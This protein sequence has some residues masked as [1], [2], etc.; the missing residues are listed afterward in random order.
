LAGTRKVIQTTGSSTHARTLELG[1]LRLDVARALAAVD[2][3]LVHGR[4]DLHLLVLLRSHAGR[5]RLPLLPH[6]T[7]LWTFA[8]DVQ[9]DGWARCV[10]GG[11]QEAPRCVFVGDLLEVVHG[12]R[13]MVGKAVRFRTTWHL[14]FSC[15]FTWSI[16]T[17]H[18]AFGVSSR[19]GW[20][21]AIDQSVDAAENRRLVCA[22]AWCTNRQ[23]V[24]GIQNARI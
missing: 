2:V 3:H 8:T 12:F 6:C 18:A 5:R 1:E 4:L 23:F 24:F 19:S 14:A 9:G 15:K 22:C 20:A 11:E 16:Q 13:K 17:H 7:T 10:N 21:V